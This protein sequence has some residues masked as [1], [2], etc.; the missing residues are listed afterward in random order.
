MEVG[1]IQRKPSEYLAENIYATFQ[2]DYSV[3][4][5]L[6]GVNLERV[7]WAS[8][9]PHGDGTYPKSREVAADVTSTMNDEQRHAILYQN[10]ASLY[11][12]DFTDGS[13]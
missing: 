11:G 3:K 10:A 8:D 1:S 7:M 6:D 13:P 2:D 12:L 4:L 5:V 9:F